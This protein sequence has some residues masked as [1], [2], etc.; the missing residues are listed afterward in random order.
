MDISDRIT[1]SIVLEYELNKYGERI[2]PC[3]TKKLNVKISE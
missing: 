1:V 3:G 2:P